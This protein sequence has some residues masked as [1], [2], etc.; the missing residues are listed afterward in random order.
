MAEQLINELEKAAEVI[1]APPNLISVQQ[2]QSAE[3]VFLSFRKTNCPYELCRQILETNTNDYI[4]FEAADL[5]KIALVREWSTLSKSDISSLKEY[6]FHYII[7]KPNLAAYIRAVISQIIAIIIKRGSIDDGGQERQHMLDKLE[8]MIMT[9][10]LPQKLLACNLISVIIQ[11][12]AFNC[13]TSNIYLPLEAHIELKRQFQPDL[14]RIF[15]FSMRI[16]EELIKKDLQ[17]DSI[18][19]LKQLL[20]ILEDILSWPFLNKSFPYIMTFISEVD[21][22]TLNLPEEWEDVLLLPSVLDLF[23]TLYWKVREYPQLTY[24]ARACLGQLANVNTATDSKTVQYVS[25]YMERFLKFVTS[26]DIIDQEAVG[27]AN[28]VKELIIFQTKYLSEDIIKLLLEQL[29]RLT[30]LFL[31]SAAQEKSLA[32]DESLYMEA[33]NA[34][35][36]SWLYIL[37]EKNQQSFDFCKQSFIQIFDTYLRYRLAPPEGIRNIEEKSLEKEEQDCEE[38]DRIRFKDHLQIMGLIGRQILHHSLP[39]LAQLIE[40]RISKMRE[41]FN[42]LVGRTESLENSCMINLYEDIHWLVLIIGNIL[43]MESEGE[44]ALIPSEIITYDREQAQ[45]GKVDVNLTLQFLASSDNISSDININT[46][47]IDH[48]IRLIADVF[49]LCA[50]EKTAISIHLDSMLSPELSCT[51]TWFLCKLSLNYLPLVES[52]YL[53]IPP[54]FIKAFGDTPGVSWIVNFLIEKVE[55]NISTFKSEPALMTETINLLLSLV[56]SPK[57]ASYVL[58]S[59]RFGSIVNLATKEQYDLPRLVKRGLMQAAG[60]IVSAAQDTNTKHSYWNQILQPLLNKLPLKQL[61]TDEKFLQSYHREDVKMQVMD[62]LDRLIG[63]GQGTKQENS[64]L[65]LQHIYPLLREL[66]NLL[67]LYHNYHEVMELIFELLCVYTKES[68]ALYYLSQTEAAQMYE[69]CLRTIQNYTHFNSN[70]RTAS[71][72]AEDDNYEDIM[73]LM[74]LLMNLNEIFNRDAID[75]F[76]CGAS[77]FVPIMTIDLLKFPLLCSQYLL[78]LFGLKKLTLILYHA[79]VAHFTI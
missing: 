36:D 20:P 54:I 52:H 40:N 59:E 70:R 6:L 56:K 38:S 46:E 79:W 35:F 41:N 23:F 48:V 44:I 14:K 26:V 15:K 60:Q 37:S 74:H 69:I 33:L 63:V 25:N 53:E 29:S 2:R 68:E 4:L 64:E 58:K 16:V 24:H 50:I 1:L 61:T 65:L 28:I 75:A 78:M 21:C 27:I 13:K 76:L 71:T 7:S 8:N 43:C 11:E 30:Y 31:E 66:P 73:L 32:V 12:Y 57:R 67:S 49:R 17:E 19:L 72:T 3:Q 47:S 34:L 77:M 39:L 55:F 51:I 42:M 18:A 5:I 22:H 62:I 10:N 45:E 9:A